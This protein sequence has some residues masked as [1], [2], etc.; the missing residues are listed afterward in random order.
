MG[1]L[2][3]IVSTQRTKKQ[4]FYIISL[5]III[6][7]KS[8]DRNFTLLPQNSIRNPPSPLSLPRLPRSR[9]PPPLC[10]TRRILIHYPPHR[11]RPLCRTSLRC[12]PLAFLRRRNIPT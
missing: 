5:A 6:R 1:F 3:F 2:Y 9:T 12:R 10:Q 8:N 11:Q 4:I 7:K